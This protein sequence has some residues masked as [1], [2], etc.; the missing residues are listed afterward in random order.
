M[1]I[2]PIGGVLSAVVVEA[3]RYTRGLIPSLDDK[4]KCNVPFLPVDTFP[5]A[6]H[7]LI[8]DNR[9][10]DLEGTWG[11]PEWGSPIE[12]EELELIGKPR[13]V[14][15][16]VINRAVMLFTGNEEVQRLHRVLT[17][18][19]SSRILSGPPRLRLGLGVG[20]RG[21]ST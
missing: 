10:Q 9:I 1:T 8:R 14:R 18:S 3:I 4:S 12:Y 17:A 13:N 11:D 16:E 19:G 6:I 15:I 21:V 5:G 2:D 7:N 20:E